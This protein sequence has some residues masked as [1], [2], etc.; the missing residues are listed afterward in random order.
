MYDNDW[1]WLLVDNP[2]QADYHCIIHPLIKYSDD[3]EWFALDKHDACI[4]VS[5][6]CRA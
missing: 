4:G 2:A 1:L 3:V 5:D 6:S